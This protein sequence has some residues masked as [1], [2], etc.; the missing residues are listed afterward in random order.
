MAGKL[1]QIFDNIYDKYPFLEQKINDQIYDD[2]LPF[3]TMDINFDKE[4][5]KL[6]PVDEEDRIHCKLYHRLIVF[7]VKNNNLKITTHLDFKQKNVDKQRKK[8]IELLYKLFFKF[9][10][11]NNIKL[12]NMKFYYYVSD[13]HAWEIKKIP[14][15]IFAKPVNG[16]G[17]LA[18]DNTFMNTGATD[19]NS[20]WNET[21]DIFFK[22]QF[23]DKLDIVYFNGANTGKST[24]KLRE[25]L[26]DFTK[27]D[28]DFEIILK[29][30]RIP[31]YEFGKYKYLLN[32]PGEQ[33][34]SYR[35][36][37]LFLTKSLVI[38][39]ETTTKYPDDYN[40]KWVQFFHK[41]LIPNVDYIEYTYD[42]IEND[43]KH[44]IKQTKEIIQKIK[45]LKKDM[46]KYPEKYNTIRKNGFK[47]MAKFTL[48]EVFYYM[49][50]QLL[51]YSK[52]FKNKN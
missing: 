51:V 29:G 13:T 9:L 7:K 25:Y 35:Y 41:M 40:D 12:P 8:Q 1:K 43:E 45:K 33:P 27:N 23:E 5:E 14:F 6:K 28:K 20:T 17:F 49:L 34:W 3:V 47:K 24:Y 37:Y 31:M 48:K 36:K 46:I 10:E 19:I 30:N 16:N 52:I 39:I 44:N 50:M 21:K 18:P 32:L 38:N 4:I 15:L 11:K 26:R 2:F 42:Y 22:N